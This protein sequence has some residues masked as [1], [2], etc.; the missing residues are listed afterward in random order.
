MPRLG[1]RGIIHRLLTIVTELS[2]SRAVEPLP[3]A[4]PGPRSRIAIVRT[5]FERYSTPL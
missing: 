3:P 2:T 1:R 5:A 4:E